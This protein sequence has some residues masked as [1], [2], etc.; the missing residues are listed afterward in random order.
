MVTVVGLAVKSSAPFSERVWQTCIV[1]AHTTA[2]ERARA[3]VI[4]EIKAEARRQ[5]GES[6]AAGL[7]LRA[8]ARELGMVS[9]GIYRYFP[10]RDELLTALIIDSYLDLAA[11]AQRA[12][13][14]AG[15]EPREQWRG[16]CQ[17]IRGWARRHPHEYALLYGSPV[18]GYAA[19]QDTIGPATE[20]YRTLIAP[21]RG[22]ATE[23]RG[24]RRAEALPLS[25]EAD[26]TRVA[27]DLEL[28][29]DPARMVRLLDALTGLFGHVSFELFGHTHG[30]IEDH[31][32]FFAHRVERLADDVGL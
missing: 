17:A 29:V 9:S 25:L 8:V 18:P 12:L 6:G 4:D 3:A 1:A 7:S 19:P 23:R 15:D 30:V 27:A 22:R 26:A 11:A 32:A 24:G 13:D 5:L 31:D 20:V 2:R 21:L 10:S 28:A 16:A 14:R